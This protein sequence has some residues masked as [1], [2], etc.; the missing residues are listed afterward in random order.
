M[1]KVREPVTRRV[2]GALLPVAAQRTSRAGVS[3]ARACRAVPARTRAMPASRAVPARAMPASAQHQACRWLMGTA[4]TLP[5]AVQL[6]TRHTAW[7]KPLCATISMWNSGKGKSRPSFWP[8]SPSLCS[9]RPP[10]HHQRTQQLALP[11]DFQTAKISTLSMFP[12]WRLSMHPLGDTGEFPTDSINHLLA[13]WSYYFHYSPFD[14]LHFPEESAPMLCKLTHP[15]V[16]TGHLQ[17]ILLRPC[18]LRW[19]SYRNTKYWYNADKLNC[20]EI[21]YENCLTEKNPC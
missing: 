11:Q 21:F 10:L 15:T 14:T 1:H 19:K 4:P 20:K 2:E 5:L 12:R 6:D 9:P 13:M 7:L 8:G 3:A 17:R 18:S 16:N